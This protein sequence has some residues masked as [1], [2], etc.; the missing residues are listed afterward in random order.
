MTAPQDL[1]DLLKLYNEV[2]N[3]LAALKHFIFSSTSLADVESLAILLSRQLKEW[4]CE[5]DNAV[6]LVTA[7]RKVEEAARNGEIAHPDSRCALDIDSTEVIRRALRDQLVIWGGSGSGGRSPFPGF[8]APDIFPLKGQSEPLGILVVEGV[9]P[10]KREIYQFIA[11]FAGMI[12]NMCRLHEE[13]ETQKRELSEMAGILCTQNSQ[14]Y[15][16]H[17]TGMKIVETKDTA[18]L[19][20]LV[21]DALVGELGVLRAAAFILDGESGK[22]KGI[23]AGGGLE[24]LVGCTLGREGESDLRTDPIWKSIKT[25]RIVNHKDYPGLTLLD[26]EELKSWAVF[27]FKGKERVLGVVVVETGGLDV[28]DMTAIL[29]NHAGMVLDNLLVLEEREKIN[30]ELAAKTNELAKANDSLLQAN[31]LLERIS[32]VDFLTG[33]YNHRYFHD[34]FETEFSRAM[35]YKSMLS[36]IMIDVD[37]FKSI[38]DRYGHAVGDMVLKD[39]AARI[40]E[41]TRCSDMVSR[42]GGDEIAILLPEAD[43]EAAMTVAA[44]LKEKV[45][46]KPVPANGLSIYV[47]ISLGVASYPG[48]DVRTQNDLFTKA[49][50][51]LYQVKEA[52]NRR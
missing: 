22:L 9:E 18:G 21:V 4:I 38:N 31:A 40:R 11:Q 2:Y 41:N 29:V 15:T 32:T 36:L 46:E 47:S 45:G 48:P 16:L 17:H 20:G 33:L 26:A 35:R 10:Q 25:R 39:V 12:L 43:L 27:P 50:Q 44:K 14:L 30:D 23:A 28:S 7:E 37:Y 19:C 42:Y 8:T 3:Q 52:R 51:A 24:R 49:D 5:S 34:R 13:V 1:Q 6:W